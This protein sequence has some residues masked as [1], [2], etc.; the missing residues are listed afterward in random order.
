MDDLKELAEILTELSL[1]LRRLALDLGFFAVRVTAL[2]SDARVIQI[3]RHLV[4]LDRHEV[5]N[6]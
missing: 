2:K 1:A 4:R 3:P 5:S 6:N